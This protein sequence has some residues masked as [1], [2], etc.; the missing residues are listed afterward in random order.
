MKAIFLKEI[1]S[2]FN[3]LI[4]YMF[5]G[6]FLVVNGLIMWVF[7][8]TNVF[9]YGYASMDTLFS[10]T[11]YVFIFL[12]PAITMRTFAEEK[13]DGTLELLLTRPIREWE[14]ILGKFSASF[15]IVFL[16]L[17]P[18]L[19]YYLSIYQLGLPKGN[20]DSAAVAGSYIG[21]LLLALVF[22]AIGIFSSSVTENQ[23]VAFILGTFLCFVFFEGFEAISK[24]N[25]WSGVSYQL[26]KLGISYN[27]DS[28][29]RGLIDSRNVLYLT[30]LIFLFLLMTKTILS[31][32]KW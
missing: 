29:S 15:T 28:L 14:L 30:S 3:S 10:F 11:P 22:T 6:V 31:S 8:D 9:S 32:R 20:I 27:Y 18:T 16:A 7:P 25:I 17:L 2:F 1:N 5:I 21:L 23:I 12:I 4:A 24:I 13:K 26:Q 19:I